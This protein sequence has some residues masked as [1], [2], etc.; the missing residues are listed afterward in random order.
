[1]AGNVRELHNVIERA[2]VLA[3]GE[4]IM[5]RDLPAH[6]GGAV[7]AAQSIEVPLGVS[8]REVE[9]LVI[10]KT[11]EA[12]DGDKTSAARI[13]GI[14]SRT[15]YRRLENLNEDSTAPSTAPTSGSPALPLKPES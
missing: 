4:E 7:V 3:R 8:L 15:I 11:L 10:R 9:D 6:L 13:L 14:N 2:V 1:M 12:T 5:E